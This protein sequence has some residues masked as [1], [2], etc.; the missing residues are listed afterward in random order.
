[1]VASFEQLELRALRTIILTPITENIIANIS[2]S[3]ISSALEYYKYPKIY[4][5]NTYIYTTNYTYIYIYTHRIISLSIY[6]YTYIIKIYRLW[7]SL[8][9]SSS[10]LSLSSSSLSLSSSTLSL[11]L[12]IISYVFGGLEPCPPT[13]TTRGML[14]RS[15]TQR[16]LHD[17]IILVPSSYL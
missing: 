14:Q 7:S 10:S 12:W 2:E 17:V 6:I 5:N 9:L 13:W 11:A 3:Y 1:M 4:T 8:S 16:M 15:P